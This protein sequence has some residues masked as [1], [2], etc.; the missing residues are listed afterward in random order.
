MCTKSY[1]QEY[2]IGALFIV[3]QNWKQ[4]RYSPTV[5]WINHSVFIAIQWNRILQNKNE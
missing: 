5:E 2:S 3:A 4:P 1:V